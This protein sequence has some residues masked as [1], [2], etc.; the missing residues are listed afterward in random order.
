VLSLKAVKV[1][2]QGAQV[3]QRGN[4]ISLAV[5]TRAQRA[6]QLFKSEGERLTGCRPWGNIVVSGKM[7]PFPFFFFLNRFK[8]SDWATGGVGG[9]RSRA[10][11]HPPL[12]E[13]PT[14]VNFKQNRARRS[15]R[16]HGPFSAPRR[17]SIAL[18]QQRGRKSTGKNTGNR[19]LSRGG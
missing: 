9:S 12:L 4:D 10:R 6:E 2:Q 7:Q 14:V 18:H 13:G 17:L 1:R 15:V 5:S 8:G 11:I 19:S 16:L 3:K